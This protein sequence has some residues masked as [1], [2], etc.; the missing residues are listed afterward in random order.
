MYKKAILFLCLWLGTF[1]P[2]KVYADEKIA[3]V[4]LERVTLEA[5]VFASAHQQFSEKRALFENE[6]KEQERRLAKREETLRALKKKDPKAFEKEQKSFEGDLQKLYKKLQKRKKALKQ[7][8]EKEIHAAQ[9]KMQ[10]VLQKISESKNI[11]IILNKKDTF[12]VKKDLDITRQV[13]DELNKQ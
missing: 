12:L 6:L 7:T 8:Y 9:E 3:V 13:I 5:K 1:A 4:D 10:A 11:A 2:L